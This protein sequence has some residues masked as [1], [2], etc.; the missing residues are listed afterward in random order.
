VLLQDYGILKP[1]LPLFIY[2]MHIGYTFFPAVCYPCVFSLHSG[3]A[4]NKTDDQLFYFDTKT[5]SASE[6]GD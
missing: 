4:A 5:N 2:A 6:S 1:V 3:L